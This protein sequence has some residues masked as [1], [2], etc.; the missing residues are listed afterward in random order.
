[1]EIKVTKVYTEET[2]FGVKKV[3]CADDGKKYRVGSRQRFYDTVQEPGIY[4]LTMGDFQ[5]KPFVK[6]LEF[7]KPLDDN[8]AAPVAKDNVQTAAAPAGAMVAAAE[9]LSFERKK[10]DDIILEFYTG[11]AKD[12]CIANK[13]GNELIDPINVQHMAKKMVVSHKRI[14]SLLDAE[15]KAMEV[16]DGGPAADKKVDVQTDL[17]G[18]EPPF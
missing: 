11:I 4:E 16:E 15:F 6:W 1:M 14:L 3:L 2:K 12:I 7:V 10:Q 8:G 5:G 17:D 9:K 13:Q 18:E